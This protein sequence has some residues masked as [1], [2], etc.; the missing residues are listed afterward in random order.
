[1][2]QPGVVD[3]RAD[4][5][6]TQSLVP[7]AEQWVRLRA[8]HLH[9]GRLHRQQPAG[10]RIRPGRHAR[11]PQ[12]DGRANHRRDS[13]R[14]GSAAAWRASAQRVSVG[15]SSSSAGSSS[16]E[17]CFGVRAC[18][19][20]CFCCAAA[21]RGLVTPAGWA[22]GWQATGWQAGRVARYGCRC[23]VRCP[24]AARAAGVGCAGRVRLGRV[25]SVRRSVL[26]LA[27]AV[28]IWPGAALACCRPRPPCGCTAV[29]PGNPEGP[30]LRPSEQHPPEEAPEIA[31]YRP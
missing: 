6:N 22:Q 31:L 27:I 17:L 8:F 28:V 12:A 1:M 2:P 24:V 10:S 18:E 9:G 7:A 23:R 19:C 11:L 30:Y 29:S 21:R 5:N 15:D 4:Y 14:G 13:R 25:A 16:R 3:A 20:A 26:A